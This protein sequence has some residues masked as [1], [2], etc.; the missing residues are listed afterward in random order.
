MASA[1]A[2]GTGRMISPDIVA[3]AE[4]LRSL[5]LPHECRHLVELLQ[6]QPAAPAPFERPGRDEPAAGVMEDELFLDLVEDRLA[7]AATPAAQ[8]RRLCELRDRLQIQVRFL[9]ALQDQLGGAAAGWGAERRDH[10]EHEGRA[11]PALRPER[12]ELAELL[13]RE[14]DRYAPEGARPLPSCGSRAP[15]PR[16][17]T[18]FRSLSG[19]FL[20]PAG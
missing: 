7:E 18:G 5:Y 17:E 11:L 10:R 8:F 6:S 2:G 1:V 9:D 20:A 13:R 15:G 19:R 12:K 14:Q 3:T 4:V 16:G